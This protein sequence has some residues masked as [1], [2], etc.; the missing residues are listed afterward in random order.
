MVARGCTDEASGDTG[1]SDP[2]TTGD[3][4]W[5]AIAVE[6]QFELAR[7]RRRARR[8]R[9]QVRFRIRQVLNL[10]TALHWRPGG[11]TAGLGCIHRY[12]GSW[13]DPSAPYWGGLQMDR[14]FMARYAPV[15]V[16]RYGLADRWPIEAQLA[17]GVLAYYDGRGFG[18]WPNTSR[19]CGL[20]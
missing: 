20:R 5:Q 8:L 2:A 3:V 11:V 19:L 1:T 4:D 10:R 7:E 15:M 14:S 12:E 13:R 9:R 6:R 18:P 17:A 16:R